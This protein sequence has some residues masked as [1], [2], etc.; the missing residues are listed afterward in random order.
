MEV[1]KARKMIRKIINENEAT[2][3]GI[4]IS[5][6][7][8]QFMQVCNLSEEDFIR[9]LKNSLKILGGK[10]ERITKNNDEKED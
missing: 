5:M 9:S 10:N 3:I 6:L 2:E 1:K 4:F 7:S 8:F